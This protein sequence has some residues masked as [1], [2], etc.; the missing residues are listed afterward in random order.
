MKKSFTVSGLVDSGTILDKPNP[1]VLTKFKDQSDFSSNSVLNIPLSKIQPNPY[2]P[3][4]IFP[5]KEIEKLASSIEE[6]GLL[7]P[8]AVRKNGL[9]DTYQI[10]AGERRY[11]AYQQ[12]NKKEI[13]GFVFV[14]DDGD[15]AVMAIVE[16]VNREDLSDYEIGKAIR[17]VENLFP[18][19]TKLAE[20]CGFQR[21]D[22]Y[23]YF[24]FE[25]L[26]G[27]LIDKLDE[28]PRL[29][30]RNASA[31]IKRVLSK[32]GPEHSELAISILKNAINLLEKNELDQTKIAQH[33]SFSMKQSMLELDDTITKRDEFII[34]GLKIGYISTSPNGIIIKFS[35]GILDK[36]KKEQLQLLINNFLD[37][38][39]HKRKD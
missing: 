16:N 36:E 10:I 15:L 38:L 19:K 31:D 5:E 33:I 23:R 9:T 7:Q 34:D 21:E 35:S 37:E 3:R 18:S 24:S 20:A 28:N 17:A 2:Q 1:S 27:F 12:L 29:L 8:I 4:R 30:S 22:M 14:C 32:I 6:V 26:P 25:E 11:K 39:I 13:P